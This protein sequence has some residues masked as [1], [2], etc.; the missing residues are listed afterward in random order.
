MKRSIFLLV[1]FFLGAVISFAQPVD[2][3]WVRRYNGTGNQED[4]AYA[5]AVDGYGYVYI[6]G[7]SWGSGKTDRDYATVKYDSSGDT[8]W[9][10]RYNGSGN[11]TDE[12]SAITVD[13]SGNVYVCGT[14]VGV[15]TSEDYLTIKYC[16][17]GDTAWIR[18]YNGPGDDRDFAY[19]LAVDGSGNV[20]VTGGSGGSGTLWGYATIKYYPDGDTAWI[21]RYDGA[22][23]PDVHAAAMAVDNSGNVYVTG[24]SYAPETDY[25]CATIK[26]YPGGDTAWVRRY[27][28]VGSLFFEGAYAIGLDGSGNVYATGNSSNIGTSGDYVTVKYYPDGDTA[29]V[30]GY[31][32]PGNQYDK[33]SALAVDGW[34]NV[35][36]T[37]YSYRSGTG[38][39]YLTI[40]YN[41]DGDT[42]WVR[43]Y[44]G[45][46]NGN[47]RANDLAVDGSGNVYVTG[48]S[49]GSGSYHDY[50]TIKYTSNGDIAW[51][52]RYEGPGN[53]DDKAWDLAVDEWGNVYVTG[54]SDWGVTQ[55]DYLTIK[56]M[57]DEV[58][59]QEDNEGTIAQ[60]FVLF[61]NYPNPFNPSTTI[62]FSVHGK[63]ITENG[64]VRTT[65]K[66]VYGSQFIVHSPIHITLTIY[67]TL[68]QKVRTLVDE[69]KLAGEYKAVWDGRDDKGNSV[70]S[71]IYLYKLESGDFS[72]TKKMLLLR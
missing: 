22:G 51:V 17:D 19:A 24:S 47:D 67:N 12:A 33:A 1:T 55:Y 31:N 16:S 28:G 64:P 41:S 63:R 36:V 7:G 53:G 61:Q 50:A 26:Y 21:R 25:D 60:S 38:D 70:S 29:W 32:G 71:G 49:Y 56:Y 35:C 58:F 52:A 45:P 39:D 72:E 65:Q 57:Q 44:N 48:Y 5:L 34:D 43:R 62:S 27:D 23:G 11:S 13:D 8:N 20:Y 14:S 37:G 10:K 15:G 69:V 30:R 6:T 46:G 40:K 3:A 18:R 54:E 4:R 59:V 66:S 9:V 68:G 2:T 42:V